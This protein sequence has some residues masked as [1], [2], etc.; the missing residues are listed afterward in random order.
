MKWFKHMTDAHDSNDLTKVRVRYGAD[1]YA[2]YW[3]CLELVAAD[4]G[5][6]NN[7]TFELR[8]DADV[9]GHNL[10]ID[11]AKVEEM[12]R[13]MVRIGLF[14]QA[15]GIIT[16]L[17]LAKYLDKK[18]TRNETIHRIIDAASSLSGTVADKSGPSGLDTDTDTDTDKSTTAAPR[19][20]PY[21]KAFE[22]AWQIF[23]KRA[24]SNPK[25]RAFK[26]WTARVKTG[27]STE[28]MT[29]GTKRYA[30]FCRATGKI[31]TEY[32]MQ[33]ATFYGPDKRYAETWEIPK[34][35]PAT[36]TLT[37]SA[38]M[39]LGK[40]IGANPKP[41]ES[42]DSYRARVLRARDDVGRR[43]AV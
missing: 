15:G 11:A 1:G 9:I 36:G 29:E 14:E 37:D 22:E 21:S 6:R 17:K 25:P 19:P 42:M 41:G 24:G 12:M 30:A 43:Q 34:P 40:A 26:A 5:E 13:Y 35:K 39:D 23:P 18:S 8:H 27:E 3:Y 10:K 38:I 20:T 32:T 7:I 4:L 28:S 2:V 31:G 16:C 33:A